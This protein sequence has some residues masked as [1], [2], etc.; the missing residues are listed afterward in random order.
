[1]EGSAARRSVYPRLFLTAA[2]VLVLD[3]VTKEIALRTLTDGGADLIDG[4]LSLN[5]TF[6]AGGAFGIA[7]G[8]PGLFL[9]G[10]ILVAV[11]IAVWARQ[12]DDPRWLIPLGM[13]LGGGVGNLADR[14]F[15]G[16]DGRVVDFIDL[17]FWPVFN[18]A[19][20]AIVFGI[21]LILLVGLGSDDNP[22]ADA[23]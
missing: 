9:I 4:I 17:H 14:L 2:A 18:I 20:M 23:T 13:I 3:Q 7:Q 12:V 5:L 6:N 21:A 8:L 22:S 10:S 11:V 16:Y 1:M 19:D 15:R